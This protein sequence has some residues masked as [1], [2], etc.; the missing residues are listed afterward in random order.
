MRL[1]PWLFL[2]VLPVRAET[3]DEIFAHIDQ[4]SAQFKS[5]SATMKRKE[6]DAVLSETTDWKG[7]I[8][9]KRAKTGM[10]GVLDFTEP[11]PMTVYLG[12]KTA[13]RFFPKANTV[14]IYDIGKYA[15]SI[16]EVILVGFGASSADLRKQYDVKLGGTDTVGGAKTSRLELVPKDAEVRKLTTK[17]ELW[18]PEG[19]ANPIQEKLS[20]PSKNYSLINF[21]DV[22]INPQL[23]D[24]DYTLKL[25]AGAKKIYPQK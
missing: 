8:R 6:F 18:I 1:L 17:I 20:T 7:T 25:P 5:Y 21:S 10:T 2:A 15:H 24:A 3:L 14:E 22:K 19:Q 23:P 9:L 16:D 11:D 4:A 12:G 13:E